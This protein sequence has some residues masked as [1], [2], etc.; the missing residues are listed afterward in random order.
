[1]IPRISCP[2]RPTLELHEHIVL[3]VSSASNDCVAAKTCKLPECRRCVLRTIANL[4]TG[5]WEDVAFANYV[6]I[7]ASTEHHSVCLSVMLR[8]ATHRQTSRSDKKP[9]HL[10]YTCD[11]DGLS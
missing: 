11:K 8:C 1:M 10:V 3:V 2:A 9:Y 6:N 7:I 5:I 4:A